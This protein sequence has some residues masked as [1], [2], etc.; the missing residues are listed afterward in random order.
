MRR[1]LLRCHAGVHAA[2]CAG[3]SNRAMFLPSYCWLFSAAA[4][5]LLI[6][7]L[8]SLGLLSPERREENRKSDTHGRRVQGMLTR[9][10]V[11][12]PKCPQL[13]F[14][15]KMSA[16]NEACICNM[17]KSY[18]VHSMHRPKLQHHIIN[19]E[20]GHYFAR[21]Q[22]RKSEKVGKKVDRISQSLR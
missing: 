12:M 20:R 4:S 14:T 10:Q 9:I 18:T 22:L 3:T 6:N 7:G 17:L 2:L 16:A 15:G 13:D 19:L 11:E 8:L 1:I 5:L 21:W